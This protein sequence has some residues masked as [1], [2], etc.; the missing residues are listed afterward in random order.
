MAREALQLWFEAVG[1]LDGGGAGDSK[2][3]RQ[4]LKA[5]F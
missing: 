5:D 3:K 1:M 2:G 4:T